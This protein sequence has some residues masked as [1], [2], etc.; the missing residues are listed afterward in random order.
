MDQVVDRVGHQPPDVTMIITVTLNTLCSPHTCQQ[1]EPVVLEVTH[2]GRH[3][4][5]AV[6]EASHRD[7]NSDQLTQHYPSCPHH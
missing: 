3:I 5:E 7:L 6:I 1:P 4:E 2:A